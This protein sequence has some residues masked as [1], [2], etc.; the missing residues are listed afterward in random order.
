[1]ANLDITI[2]PIRAHHKDVWRALYDGY[3]RFYG[4]DLSDKTAETVWGWLHD[5]DHVLQGVI[6][7]AGIRPVGLAHFRPAP[8][9]LR[10]GEICFLDDLFVVPEERAQG[11]GRALITHVRGIA[12]RRGWKTVRWITA[13]DNHGAKGL[14]D[15]LADGQSWNFYEMSI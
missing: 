10:G 7:F 11:A 15:Q 9:P 14:Y 4:A 3:A 6:A 5:R 12:R 13:A 2:E 1:M 8:N